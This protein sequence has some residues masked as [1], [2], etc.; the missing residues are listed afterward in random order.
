MSIETQT[1][2]HP[3][4]LIQ[5]NSVVIGVDLP[6]IDGLEMVTGQAVYGEDQPVAH[7]AFAYLRTQV[8]PSFPVDSW[9][10]KYGP[11]IASAAPTFVQHHRDDSNAFINLVVRI[12]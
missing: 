10:A 7:I 6:R 1:E 4:S 5:S 2:T 3:Q 9:P 8:S 11:K 12:P